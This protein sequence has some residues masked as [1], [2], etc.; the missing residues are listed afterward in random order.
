MTFPKFSDPS[1]RLDL[2]HRL[3]EAFGPGDADSAYGRVS[4]VDYFRERDTNTEDQEN[5]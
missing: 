1:A 3:D 5:R 2:I 4:Y